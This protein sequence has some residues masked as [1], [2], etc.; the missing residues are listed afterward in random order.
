[1]TFL[2]QRDAT[3]RRETASD[4]VSGTIGK[5]MVG[6][7]CSLGRSQTKMKMK[8]A[9]KMTA[10]VN[11]PDCLRIMMNDT[12]SAMSLIWNPQILMCVQFFL[13]NLKKTDGLHSF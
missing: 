11:D 5:F 3:V 2:D 10:L 1:M 9:S 7:Q 4:K 6:L 12:T 8:D 13:L